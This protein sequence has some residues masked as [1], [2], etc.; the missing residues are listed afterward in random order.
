MVYVLKESK[1]KK[2]LKQSDEKVSNIVSETIKK[3]E[4]EGDQTL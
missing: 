2:E 1:D 3:I 4:S